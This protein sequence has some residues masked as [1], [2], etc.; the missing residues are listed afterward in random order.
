MRSKR[1]C[2]LVA[3]STTC[4]GVVT[5]PQSCS[6]PAISQFVAILVGHAEVGQRAL[7]GVVHRF[8]QHH[9]EYRHALAVAAGIGRLLVDRHVDEVG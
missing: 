2:S 6:R 3:L 7:S 4:T 8:G 1:V 5:L 9:G